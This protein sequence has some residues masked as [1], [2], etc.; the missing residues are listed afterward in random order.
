MKPFKPQE[1]PIRDI[2][3]EPLIPL[4]GRANRS[5]ALYDGILYGV[6]NPEVL[7]SPLATRE[8]VLSSRIEGTQATLSEV[9]KSEAGEEPER[10]TRR[11]DIVEIVNYRRALRHGEKALAGKPF[12]LNL[13]LELHSILLESARGRNMGRGRFRNT[14]N[15]IGEAGSPVEQ[16]EF[17]PPA[18]ENLMPALD[19][20]EKHYH[21]ESP[22]GLVQIAVIHAQFEIIHPFL[23]GNG[24]IGRIVIPLFLAEKGLLSRP[25]F[26]LSSYLERHRDEYIARLRDIGRRNDGWN[27]WIGFFLRAVGE[28]ARANADKAKAIIDLYAD[29][30][31]RVLALTRSQYAIPLLDQMF[32]RPLFQSGMLRFP[33]GLAPSRQAVFHLIRQLRD[34]G[35][36]EVVRDARGRRAQIL[37]LAELIDICEGEEAV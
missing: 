4:I 6:P 29:L 25:M 28:E 8:A 1:L 17:V 33:D 32:E 2:E 5:L 35:I 24:R 3:W 31:E 23:D 10:E 18:P 7:L 14:Q 36:L 21:A 37:A 19:A 16:A 15:W 30:K 13:L 11:Q 12:N 22:D 34:N 9:L 20:W 26:Y 27:R